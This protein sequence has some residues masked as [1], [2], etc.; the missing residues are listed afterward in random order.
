MYV[1][2]NQDWAFWLSEEVQKAVHVSYACRQKNPGISEVLEDSHWNML[3][4]DKASIC[5]ELAGKKFLRFSF[6]SSSKYIT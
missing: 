5:T 2:Y 1:K 4:N 3:E 6:D